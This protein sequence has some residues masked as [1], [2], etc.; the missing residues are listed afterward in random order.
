MLLGRGLGRLILD[1][2]RMC[3]VHCGMCTVKHESLVYSVR[4]PL[5]NVHCEM[6]AALCVLCRMSP[7]RCTRRMCLVKCVYTAGFTA[8]CV[9]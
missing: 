3:S 5:L 8:L 2:R 7:V 6:C 9:E 1:A 4:C